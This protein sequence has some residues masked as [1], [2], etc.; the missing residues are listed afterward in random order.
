MDSLVP[1]QT[2]GGGGI[3]LFAALALTVV[4]FAGFWKTFEKAGEP[5]WAGIIPI[6][7]LYVLV[8]ISGNA[9]WWF[10]LFFIPVVNFFAT[11]KISIDVAGKFNRGVLFGL[12]LAFLS[13]IFYPVL[14]FGDYQYQDATSS[15]GNAV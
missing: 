9:W 2:N 3:E 5:G 13:F 12:G 7:N 11:V 8:R 4:I 1:L 6:Y 10:V 15:A 14:G